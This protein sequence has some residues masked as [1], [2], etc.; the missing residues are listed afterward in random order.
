MQNKGKRKKGNL[1]ASQTSPNIERL[2]PREY[3]TVFS[4]LKPDWTIR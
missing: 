4:W 2:I 3:K 1:I